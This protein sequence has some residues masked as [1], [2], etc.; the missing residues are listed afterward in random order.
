[1]QLLETEGWKC[2]FLTLWHWGLLSFNYYLVPSLICALLV[3]YGCLFLLFLTGL[4]ALAEDTFSSIKFVKEFIKKTLLLSLFYTV[5][6]VLY[7]FCREFEELCVVSV[8]TATW[9]KSFRMQQMVFGLPCTGLRRQDSKS[10]EAPCWGIDHVCYWNKA[11][12]MEKVCSLS[13]RVSWIL[14]TG[15]LSKS[16]LL[17]QFF[18]SW[19]PITVF[20]VILNKNQ[21]DVM[22]IQKKHLW[23][24]HY[25]FLKVEF[26]QKRGLCCKVTYQKW[27]FQCFRKYCVYIFL[28]DSHG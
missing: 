16:M 27:Q 14:N 25:L 22:F 28:Q 24:D 4:S 19:L 17:H 5:F 13:P 8:L 15:V 11:T 9:F 23:G 2:I 18:T 26:I 21:S 20:M 12:A 1:M 7:V 3:F 10:T 6:Q